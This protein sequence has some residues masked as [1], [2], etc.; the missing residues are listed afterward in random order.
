MTQ[1]E[2]EEQYILDA[3]RLVQE[4]YRRAAQPYMDR[5]VNLRAMRPSEPFYITQEQFDALNIKPK[6]IENPQE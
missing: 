3:L 2:E 6:I 5:L 4:S 1:D